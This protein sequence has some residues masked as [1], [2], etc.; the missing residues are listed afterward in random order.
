MIG[1]VAVTADAGR[2]VGSVRRVRRQLE[3]G[4][5]LIVAD[6]A[7]F[8]RLAVVVIRP[9][10]YVAGVLPLLAVEELSSFFER[11]IAK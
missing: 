5:N 7:R 10:Q 6:G 11:I 9:D 1:T 8:R 3:L 2:S 4:S